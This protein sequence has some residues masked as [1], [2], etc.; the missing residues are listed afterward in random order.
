MNT[1][2][3]LIALGGVVAASVLGAAGYALY[4]MG[5]DRGMG[6]AAAPVAASASAVDAAPLQALPQGIAEGEDATRRH[7]FTFNDEVQLH[8]TVSIGVV[9]QEAP[10]KHAMI[11]LLLREADHALY[12]AKDT[13]RNR[14]VMCAHA[15]Y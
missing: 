9:H 2:P 15:V 5:M 4:A 8:I 6:M 7:I 3:L 12:E 13:G 1:K 10:P 11:E 14:V